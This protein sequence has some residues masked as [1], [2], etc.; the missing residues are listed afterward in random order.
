M[1]M[2]PSGR[3]SKQRKTTAGQTIN[4]AS[5]K[6]IVLESGSASNSNDSNLS[7]TSSSSSSITNS[8]NLNNNNH[9]NLTL[10]NRSHKT[11]TNSD[12][13]SICDILLMLYEQERTRSTQLQKQIEQASRQQRSRNSSGQSHSSESQTGLESPQGPNT[14]TNNSTRMLSPATWISTSGKEK[15][16]VH[17]Q[18]SHH[19]TLKFDAS[20]NGSPSESQDV[21]KQTHR[22][23]N[24]FYLIT[25]DFSVHHRI[26]IR[27][28]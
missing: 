24:L 15:T 22:L 23:K 4:D 6:S 14:A 1:N 17:I 2:I 8:A 18:Q 11:K 27:A 9:T 21:R 3:P 26:R 20:T 16:S 28:V 7:S 5:S 19:Q 10:T 12:S 25:I 13:R